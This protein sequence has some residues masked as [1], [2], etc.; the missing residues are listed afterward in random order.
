MPKLNS[1]NEWLFYLES[2]HPVE[3]DMGLERISV[4]SK[5]LSIEFLDT[6]VITVAGTNGKGT[7]CAFLENALLGEGFDVAVYSSPHIDVFNERLRFNK[8][9]V[10]DSLLIKAFERIEQVRAEISLTYYEYTTLAALIISKQKAPDVLILEVGLG[11]R[12]D[13][14]NLI[15]ADI[16]VITSIDLDHQKFLGDNRSAIGM[17]KAGIVRANKPVV[18]GDLDVPTK[19]LNFC[20]NKPCQILLRDRDFTIKNENNSWQWKNASTY[21][22]NLSPTYI[23]QDNVATALAVLCLLKIPLNSQ[24]VNSWIST[25]K[26]EG[27]TEV[28]SQLPLVVLDV[29]HNPH[30]ARYLAKYITKQNKE[31]VFAVSAM[32]ADKDI[33]ATIGELVNTVDQW[34][35]ASLDIPRGASAQRM[36]KA[37]KGYGKSSNHFDNVYDAYKMALHNSNKNDMILIFG[38]FFTVAEIKRSL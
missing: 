8:E 11:G 7:T 24:K 4:V 33:E 12:L 2:I 36:Q 23:P 30:A 3:I 31:N 19:V 1:L 17:E 10:D 29:G 15:D 5:R 14:T 35:V 26:V 34:Y 18:I 32:L 16:A 21:L 28:V 13:A 38:S 6:K 25:T 27:R 9:L 22:S 37:L 20:R